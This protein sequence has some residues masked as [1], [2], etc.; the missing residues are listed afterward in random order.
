M[1][2]EKLLFPVYK[3][4]T[5]SYQ[6]LPTETCGFLFLCSLWFGLKAFK[7]I[8]LSVY[9]LSLSLH[10]KELLAHP[11]SYTM[12]SGARTGRYINMKVVCTVERAGLLDPRAL[13][14]PWPVASLKIS[15]EN[16]GVCYS[17][18]GDLFPPCSDF[19][20]SLDSASNRLLN[21]PQP[22]RFKVFSLHC[23]VQRTQLCGCA[24]VLGS[25]CTPV[26]HPQGLACATISAD[27]ALPAFPGQTLVSPSKWWPSTSQEVFAGSFL[28][29]G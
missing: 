6:K 26:T 15:L 18:H 28:R 11:G 5:E 22:T 21:S 19:I 20:N 7:P 24:K 25:P 12:F 2:L 4:E 27:R 16:C 9:R 14:P 23:S 29:L 10:Y 3:I 8:L 13:I 17:P 1:F